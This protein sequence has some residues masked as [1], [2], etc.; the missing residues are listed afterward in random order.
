MLHDG[1]KEHLKAL[2][3]YRKAVEMNLTTLPSKYQS[4]SRICQDLAQLYRET[5]DLDKVLKDFFD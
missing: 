4:F 3:Y 5:K 2:Q 1:M